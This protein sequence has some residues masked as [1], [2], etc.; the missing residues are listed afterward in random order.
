M[1]ENAEILELNLMYIHLKRT[2]KGEDDGAH[3]PVYLSMIDVATALKVR[4]PGPARN[5]EFAYFYLSY[6]IEEFEVF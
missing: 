1:W 4:K 2:L 6:F 5:S 3:F